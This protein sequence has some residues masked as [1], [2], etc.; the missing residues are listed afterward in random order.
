MGIFSEQVKTRN[1]AEGLTTLVMP[2]GVKDVITISGSILGGSLHTITKN[3]KIPSLAAAMLDKGTELKDKYK[4]SETLESVGAELN[5][6]ST[7]HHT[8]FTGFCLKNNLKSVISLLAEQMQK[9]LFSNEELATLKTRIIGNLERQKEDTKKRAT[10]G[11]LRALF[12]QTHPNYRET[13]EKSIQ[14]IS[15][16]TSKELATFHKAAYGLG[17]LNIVAAGDLQPQ[18]FNALIQEAFGGWSL[19]QLEL[20]PIIEKAKPPQKGSETIHVPD[21]TSTDVFIGQPIGIDREHENYYDLMMA[22]YILGG[23]FSARLM[24]TVRDQQGLT[25]GIG[26]SISGVSSGSDGYWST[27]GTFAP[28]ILK[29]GQKATMDQIE[30]WFKKGITKD[31]LSAKKTTISGSF[32]VSMDSTS[33]L[34]GKILSNAEQGRPIDYLDKYPE[35]IN[36]LTL[37]NVNAAIKTYIDPKNLFTISAGT[38]E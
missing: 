38:D 11:L 3:H 28:E 34:T 2:T 37:E 33:G 1:I 22:V 15:Q 21:K 25:Y 24:Q 27:W 16:V 30:L 5:F 10:I 17:S 6:S 32:K 12:P 19:R 23:N 4:I 7:Q 31:E 29:K 8:N 9:P 35:I 18:A 14:L 20:P 36:S 13:L 26:S